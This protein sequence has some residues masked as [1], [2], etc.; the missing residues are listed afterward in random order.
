MPLFMTCN[1]CQITAVYLWVVPKQQEDIVLYNYY[2]VGFIIMLEGFCA[3]PQPSSF[4]HTPYI[5]GI[6]MYVYMCF[7]FCWLLPDEK[8][9]QGHLYC[10][11]R[12]PWVAKERLTTLHSRL[13]VLWFSEPCYAH[14]VCSTVLICWSRGSRQ[15]RWGDFKGGRIEFVIERLKVLDWD[16]VSE[17]QWHSG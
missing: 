7:L 15:S 5:Q 9:T 2:D 1:A 12:S 11:S 14:Y 13:H 3:R 6:Y 4:L 10:N 8:T 17:S 16:S